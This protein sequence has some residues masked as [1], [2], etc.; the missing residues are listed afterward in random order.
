MVVNTDRAVL[1]LDSAS[2]GYGAFTVLAD[3]S[4]TVQKGQVVAMM[5]VQVPEKQHFCVLRP[6][7]FVLRKGLLRFLARTWP[8]WTARLCAKHVN[9]WACC[10]NKVPYLPT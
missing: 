9:A 5:G 8:S 2:L 10:F 3:V 1:N 7:K 6:D 4:M